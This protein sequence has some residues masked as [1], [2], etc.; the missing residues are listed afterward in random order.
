M[1]KQLEFYFDF[2]S[3]NAYLTHHALKGVAARTGAEVVYHPVLLGGIFKAT[4]NQ[5]PMMAFSGVKGKLNYERLEFARFIKKHGLS[6]FAFN[7][8]FPVNT[9]LLMRGAIAAQRDGSLMPYVEAG[10]AAM[11]EEDR[12]VADP[13]VFVTVMNGAGLDGAA[14]LAQPL[15]F[16]SCR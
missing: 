4:G 7:S 13:D 10:L 11:W 8:R 2:G 16:A 5:P 12:D 6:R 1:P 15:R 3:P 14:L 9:L